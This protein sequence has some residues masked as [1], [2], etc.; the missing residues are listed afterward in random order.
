MGPDGQDLA[1][2]LGERGHGIR[3]QPIAQH[4]HGRVQRRSPEEP[5][6]PPPCRGMA[7]RWG[8]ATDGPG[9]Q[10]S[11]AGD[12][13]RGG[14]RS[15]P[16]PSPNW[17]PL[18]RR[19]RARTEHLGRDEERIRERVVD[20]GRQ[21]R[22]PGRVGDP[23]MGRPAHPGVRAP[24]R[25]HR[26]FH[27][28]HGAIRGRGHVVRRSREAPKRVLAVACGCGAPATTSGWA[29]WT[30]SARMPP[31]NVDTSPMSS[32]VIV[33]GPKSP[34]SPAYRSVSARGSSA[35][36]N[37]PS[38]SPTTRRRR[39]STGEETRIASASW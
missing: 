5:A 9:P 32:Q 7:R 35:C 33:P 12:R 2:L 11:R 30:S 19:Q 8:C 10:P 26:G 31:M 29:A 25:R 1:Q 18:L 16:V 37:S 39:L 17:S 28:R 3:H 15:E 23:A 4:A 6:Q 27:F 14:G 36:E 34:A 22:V 38:A 13:R 24:H 20:P 21:R